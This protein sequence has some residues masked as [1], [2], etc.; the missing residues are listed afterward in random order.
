MQEDG[1]TL[2]WHLEIVHEHSGVMPDDLDVPDAP[3]EL[4]YLWGYFLNMHRKRTAGAMAVDP[5]S[6]AQI[7]AW[8]QRNCIKLTPFENEC[9]DALDAVFLTMQ[10]ASKS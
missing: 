4:Q 7:L 2:R 8:Q 3:V 9:I 6:D 10:R 5:L 1:H